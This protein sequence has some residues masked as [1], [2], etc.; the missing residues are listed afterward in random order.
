MTSFP[1][2][3][4]RWSKCHAALLLSAAVGTAMSET[5]TPLL[6]TA[7]ATFA[8]L[9]GLVLC[10]RSTSAVSLPNGITVLRL[11]CIFGLTWMVGAAE[12]DRHWLALAGL[13]LLG[14]DA[15]DG[16]VAR[17]FQSITSVGALLDE[18][19][20]A[21]FLLALCAVTYYTGHLGWWILLPG[22]LRYG[23]VLLR[24]LLE[25]ETSSTKLRSRRG[26][27]IFVITMIAML[28]PFLPLPQ[29]YVPAAIGATGLLLISFAA[30]TYAL[31]QR[32]RE[33]PLVLHQQV[34]E[35]SQEVGTSEHQNV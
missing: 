1:R 16:W 19:V 28:T 24:P 30:D 29:L 27:V 31:I 10:R 33:L 21:F 23:F 35:E 25:S 6:V 13:I 11:A 9:L 32:N 34:P 17:R 14:G 4:Q 7:S 20:D 2:Q 8:A 15:L 3:L 5:I 18:E 26:R 22:L 12:V